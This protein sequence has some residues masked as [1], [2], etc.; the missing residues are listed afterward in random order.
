VLKAVST[1]VD[2]VVHGPVSDAAYWRA[3][4]I[5]MR[6]APAN[7]SIRYGGEIANAMVPSMLVEQDLL[8]LPTRGENFGHA[9]FEAMACGVPVLISDRTPWRNLEEHGVGWDLPLDHPE[10]F[11]RAIA[12]LAAMTEGERH[13]MRRRARAYS[14]EYVKTSDAASRTKAMFETV[15]RER[16]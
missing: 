8:F 5:L 9:I 2:F 1:P 7:V 4:E 6:G 12:C 3:C 15:L 10:S 14:E 16:E 13:S 11:V